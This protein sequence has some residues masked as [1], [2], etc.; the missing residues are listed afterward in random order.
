MIPGSVVVL[1]PVVL[2]KITPASSLQTKPA[3]EFE[4]E[5]NGFMMNINSLPRDVYHYRV[6]LTKITEK[7]TRDLTRG[8]KQELV[9][10]FISLGL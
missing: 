5:L 3:A 1:L 7:K 9:C 2:E 8:Q 6:S 4:V 10:T